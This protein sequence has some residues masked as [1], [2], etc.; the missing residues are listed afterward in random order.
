V[1]GTK[2]GRPRNVDV[3]LKHR[4]FLVRLK[5]RAEGHRDGHVFQGR[6]HRGQSLVRRTQDAVRCAC[7]RLGIES[8]GTH[9]FRRTWA[10]EQHQALLA[11]GLSD[12]ES[13]Q[14]LAEELGHGRVAVTYSYVPR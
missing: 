9:G 11:Q 6:G 12:H 3:D 4:E 8:Y 1:K 2:G 7:E 13:R 5:D 10:Q 14:S